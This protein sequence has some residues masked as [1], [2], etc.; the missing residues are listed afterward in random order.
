MEWIGKKMTDLEALSE[1]VGGGGV[2]NSEDL[3]KE[4]AW[5]KEEEGWK[6]EGGGFGWELWKTSW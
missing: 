4:K 6:R 2:Q 3:R 5:E 1:G